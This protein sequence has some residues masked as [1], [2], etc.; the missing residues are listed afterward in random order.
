MNY[1]QQLLDALTAHGPD[2]PD[3]AAGVLDAHPE[4]ARGRGDA[5]ESPVLLA[6]YHRQDALAQRIAT[7]RSLDALEAAALGAVEQL[8]GLVNDDASCVRARS[9][10][11]WTPLHLTAFFGRADAASVLLDAGADTEAVS[12]N[13]SANTPLCAALAGA[14]D[15]ELVRLLVTRGANVRARAG[16]G[17][18]PL[19]LAAS[20]GADALASLLLAHGAERAAA[21]DDGTTPSG[22]A[23]QRGHTAT[24]E[25]IDGWVDE[26][27][28]SG[29]GGM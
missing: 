7:M 15:P 23:R 24:A 12:D 9:W 21:M 27:A 1:T 2:G 20:R 25:L 22:I 26:D 17:V 28:G 14:S 3:G 13:P 4:A 5:G 10:D 11:G 29:R 18:T 19:H 16:H 6:L 8:R